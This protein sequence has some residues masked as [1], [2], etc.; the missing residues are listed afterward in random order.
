MMFHL[1]RITSILILV[2]FFLPLAQC[3]KFSVPEPAQIQ[4]QT[5]DREPMQIDEKNRIIKPSKTFT[6]SRLESWFSLLTFL[7]P[8]LFVLLQ[9]TKSR[10]LSNTIVLVGPILC[11][12]TIYYIGQIFRVSTPLYGGYIW[13]ISMAIFTIICITEFIKLMLEKYKIAA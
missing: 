1:K 2:T 12:I 9:N 5:E 6:T 7:W 13:I 11:G 8:T 3:Q 10:I 4:Q